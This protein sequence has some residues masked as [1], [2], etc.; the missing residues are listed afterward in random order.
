ME[1]LR[2]NYK[3][4]SSHRSWNLRQH[5]LTQ[6]STTITRMTGT[7]ARHHGILALSFL[8]C[9]FLSPFS[10][11]HGRLASPA[12]ALSRRWYPPT[13]N[14][15]KPRL[16]P[17]R[18]DTPAQSIA[19]AESGTIKVPTVHV[20]THAPKKY[21]GLAGYGLFDLELSSCPDHRPL[22]FVVFPFS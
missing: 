7:V 2:Y 20:P 5:R 3:S 19:W 10:G 11:V 22:C 17:P 1:R 4:T 14:N 6:P 13:G 15:N 8:S 9:L 21:G 12:P 18:I 16:R